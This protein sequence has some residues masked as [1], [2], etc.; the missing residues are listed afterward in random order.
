MSE[1]QILQF[2]ETGEFIDKPVLQ[3]QLIQRP[4]KCD[5]VRESFVSNHGVLLTTPNE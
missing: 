3:C 5:G 2:C 4:I 1:E